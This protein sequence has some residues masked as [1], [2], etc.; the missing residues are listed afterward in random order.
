MRV[1]TPAGFSAEA[2]AAALHKA[3]PGTTH[4][5]LASA[6]STAP[7]LILDT[8]GVVGYQ[9]GKLSLEVIGERGECRVWNP[10]F[11]RSNISGVTMA[12]KTAKREILRN[13]GENSCTMC[14]CEVLRLRRSTIYFGKGR[15]RH[16][17]APRFSLIGGEGAIKVVCKK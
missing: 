9:Q 4:I 6:E 17:P 11:L 16:R 13:R 1:C 3:R 7:N 5:E 15:A 8:E 14:V 2:A 10:P 12:I